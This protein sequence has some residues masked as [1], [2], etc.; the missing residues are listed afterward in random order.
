M[1]FKGVRVNVQKAHKLKKQ[2]AS[3]EKQFLLEIKKET[4]IDTQLWAARS[5]AK[6]FD[7][8]T[9]DGRNLDSLVSH[10]KQRLAFRGMSSSEIKEGLK[11]D[12]TDL[13]NEWDLDRHVK[14]YPTMKAEKNKGKRNDRKC[15]M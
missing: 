6:V 15:K 4:G 9:N 3:K 14:S 8:N 7:K 10:F 13:D 5:I 2:L 1:K 12:L 11:E